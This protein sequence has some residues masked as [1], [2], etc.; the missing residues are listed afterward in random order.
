M[1]VAVDV[2]VAAAAAVAGPLVGLRSEAK[3]LV[4]LCSLGICVDTLHV[5]SDG[6]VEMMRC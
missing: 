2:V 3:E 6:T 5:V 1:A 4:G